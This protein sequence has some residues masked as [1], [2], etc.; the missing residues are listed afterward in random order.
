MQLMNKSTGSLRHMLVS[1][2]MQ[3]PRYNGDGFKIECA[4]EGIKGC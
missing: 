4:H 2:L 1:W 3:K